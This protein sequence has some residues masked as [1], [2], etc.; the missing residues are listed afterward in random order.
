[1][2]FSPSTLAND[3]ANTANTAATAAAAAHQQ[4]Q[5]LF[6]DTLLKLQIQ[7]ALAKEH[8]QNR[9]SPIP[10]FAQSCALLDNLPTATTT[11]TTATTNTTWTPAQ[12]QLISSLKIDAWSALA[13]ACLQ[14]ND[15]IQAEASLQRLAM[16]Q[17]QAAGAL[18]TRPPSRSGWKKRQQQQQQQQQQQPSEPGQHQLSPAAST[19]V[20]NDSAD[21]AM[22]AVTTEQKQAAMDLLQTWRKLRQVYLDMGRQ[23]M[24]NNFSKRIDKMTAR[25]QDLAIP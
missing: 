21:A 6:A 13:D 8:V 15:L 19:Q 20:S 25:L 16:L 10:L 24:A 9:K 17:D 12:H 18:S 5:Q 3:T 14:A 4:D 1:M 11:N 23:D 22:V 7:S 2:S